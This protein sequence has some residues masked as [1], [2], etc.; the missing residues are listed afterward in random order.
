MVIYLDETYDNKHTWLLIGALFN[1]KHGK[2]YKKIR[3]LLISDRY[4][5]PDGTLK[6]IKYVYCISKKR[7]T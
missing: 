5:L 7:R 2:F 3:Q 6:E 1:P 4:I